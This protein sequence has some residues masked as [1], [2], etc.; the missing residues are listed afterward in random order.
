MIKIGFLISYDYEMLFPALNLVY[1]E[2]DKIFVS[3]D[4]ER[5]TWSGN[6]FEIPD[7]FFENL[8]KLD[9][10]NK[11]VLHEDLFFIPELELPERQTRQRILLHKKMG[12]GWK[13]F[14]DVDEYVYDFKKTANFLRKNQWIGYLPHIFPIMLRGRL[15]TLYK[16]NDQ[17]FFFID[18]GE[19]FSF[20]TNQYNF[21]YKRNN[22]RIKN[23]YTNIVAIHQSWARQEHEV[24]TKLENWCHK[25]DFN[26]KKY[27]DFWQNIDEANYMNFENIHPI[28]PIIW[29]KLEF[30]PTKTIED[31]IEHYERAHPQIIRPLTYKIIIK[32]F[33]RLNK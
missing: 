2:A 4:K 10:Q 32:S 1:K 11:I 23:H 17:G 26:T 24:W 6:P 29:K 15:I 16:K 13:V 14:L 27:F 28:N 30:L 7:S 33:L 21:L 3:I 12:K 18:N 22:K 19:R 25:Y 20:I 31:F 8:K 5:K 9:I